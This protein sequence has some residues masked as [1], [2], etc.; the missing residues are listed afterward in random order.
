MR[1]FSMSLSCLLEPYLIF[2]CLMKMVKLNLTPLPR[3]PLLQWWNRSFCY[4]TTIAILNLRFN[5][6]A[7]G[8]KYK[9]RYLL[10]AFL[11]LH[12]SKCIVQRRLFSSLARQ[13]DIDSYST[14]K[15]IERHSNLEEFTW[16]KQIAIVKSLVLFLLSAW[17]CI[18]F[19]ANN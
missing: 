7:A 15:G 9:Q 6:K 12:H 5:T 11:Y 18:S 4:S 10:Y 3:E 19:G 2:F 17:T 14:V 1:F 8:S 16:E 13:M